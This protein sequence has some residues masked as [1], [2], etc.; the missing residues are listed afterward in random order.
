MKRTILII[1]VLIVAGVLFYGV[2]SNAPI[3][4]ENLLPVVQGA[5]E[6]DENLNVDEELDGPFEPEGEPEVYIDPGFEGIPLPGQGQNS[7]DEE[8]VVGVTSE[9]KFTGTLEE[10]NTA[11]FAD[12]ECYVVVDGKKVTLLIGW[13]RDVVGQVRG[14]DGIG[15]LEEFI[16]QEVEVYGMTTTDGNYTLY[17]KEDYYVEPVAPG[18]VS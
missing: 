2:K 3:V 14:A 15:G 10:V 13:S 11:C 9:I 7:E 17:G 12:G 18:L 6:E 5:P 16:G 4:E 1:G 8:Q